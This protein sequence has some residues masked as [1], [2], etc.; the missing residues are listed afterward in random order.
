GALAPRGP[1]LEWWRGAPGPQT[2]ASA[3]AGR[4]A[5]W[6]VGCS[7]FGR[8]GP[9]APEALQ[10]LRALPADARR[11][12]LVDVVEEHLGR[13]AGLLVRSVDGALDLCMHVGAQ[14]LV[15]LVVPE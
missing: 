15:A 5:V 1:F 2:Q 14:L 4:P 11:R 3:P 12:P 9:L 10:E 6:D 8:Y 13:H 7:R